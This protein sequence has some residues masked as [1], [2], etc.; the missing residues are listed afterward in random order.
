MYKKL[1]ALLLIITFMLPATAWAAG[2]EQQARKI[3]KI[4]NENSLTATGSDAK[5]EKKK[6]IKKMKDELSAFKR[7]IKEDV[8]KIKHDAS[9]DMETKKEEIRGVREAGEDS[10][11]AIKEDIKA[12]K[13]SMK[14][15]KGRETSQTIENS[16]SVENSA[17]VKHRGKGVAN[18]MAKIV[19]NIERRMDKTVSAL[20][21]VINKFKAWLIAVGLVSPDSDNGGA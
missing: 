21:A 15:H 6:L 10:I 2:K 4:S 3:L 8:A 18:A 13:K 19:R 17:T 14:N 16:A 7:G 12:L 11:T 5:A 9:K 1:L 20:T